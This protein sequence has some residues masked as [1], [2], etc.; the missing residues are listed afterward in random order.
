MYSV[1]VFQGL[2]L[3]TDHR[4]KIDAGVYISPLHSGSEKE[5]E[6]LTA[7]L[8][9]DKSCRQSLRLKALLQHGLK[10]VKQ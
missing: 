4:M 3:S 8:T 9:K 5:S 7:V 1:C 2:Y 6:K 10:Y